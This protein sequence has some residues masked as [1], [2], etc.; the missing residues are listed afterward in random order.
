MPTIHDIAKLSGISKSTV[1]RVISKQGY[2]K[3][4]TRE[5]VEKAM[6]ELNY[7]PNYIAR[8]MRTHKSSAIG[9]FIPDNDNPFYSE[10]FKGVEQVTR[11]AGYMNLVCHT[12]E[13]PKT[14]LFYI[15]ELLKRQIDGIIFCTYNRSHEGLRYLKEVAANIPIIFM[16]PLFGDQGFSSVVSDG[17]TGSKMAVNY[18][19]ERG[20]S[21]IA[22]IKGSR[23]H[24][25][26]NER[27][28]GYSDGLKEQGNKVLRQN[29]YE[30]DFSM[31]SGRNAVK[32]FLSLDKKPDAIMAATDVMAIGAL[33]ELRKSGVKVPEDIK[34]IG[35]DNIPL[36]ELVEPALTTVAQPIKDLGINAAEL[37]LKKIQNSATP[38]QQVVMQCSII[39]RDST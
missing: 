14:E 21:N 7:T 35:F 13:D 9:L 33:K 11:K 36:A 31:E 17:Y 38:N 37:L 18:L 25:V 29:V 30:G 1:S 2:V 12:D 26:T 39:E 6:K 10:L 24:A 28:K 23:I 4:E 3:K 16:D 32:Y 34:L 22:Y 8:G 5:K 15:N 20:C 27:C 19:Y